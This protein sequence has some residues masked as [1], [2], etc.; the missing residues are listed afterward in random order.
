MIDKHFLNGI[1]TPIAYVSD[2][3]AEIEV[4][5]PSLGEPTFY[6]WINFNKK[7]LNYGYKEPMRGQNGGKPANRSEDTTWEGG[8]VRGDSITVVTDDVTN[9][10]T[11]VRVV[12]ET[13]THVIT[14]TTEEVVQTTYRP[15]SQIDNSD[16]AWA[17]PEGGD[18]R[19]LNIPPPAP[20][21]RPAPIEGPM[22]IFIVTPTDK[23]IRLEVEDTDTIEAVKAM[24]QDLEGIPSHKQ[25]LVF[26]GGKQ[27]EDGRTLQDYNLRTVTTKEYARRNQGWR[28]IARGKKIRTSASRRL[29]EDLEGPLTVETTEL[30]DLVDSC[31]ES[32]D[33]NHPQKSE[34]DDEFAVC[35]SRTFE[36]SCEQT[37]IAAV[38]KRMKVQLADMRACPFIIHIIFYFCIIFCIIFYLIF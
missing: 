17:M 29:L 24:I 38:T 31:G 36:W 30:P 10:T 37:N 14:L 35:A 26:D 21:P 19:L 34:L 22:H 27:L 18:R 28:R 9:A 1:C 16:E 2:G 3:L 20:V 13:A 32:G 12:T 23:K 6:S 4:G 15:P 25:R 33:P 5:D 7:S 11:G 8:C